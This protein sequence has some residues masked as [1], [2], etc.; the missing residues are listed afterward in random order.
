[1]STIKQKETFTRRYYLKHIAVVFASI[2]L[3]FK[4]PSYFTHTKTANSEQNTKTTGIK[5]KTVDQYK[6]GLNHER[7]L[8][9]FI[10]K[11]LKANKSSFYA[12]NGVCTHQRCALR[13][14]SSLSNIVCPC[15]G[16]RFS[17][18]GEVLRGPATKSL[19]H[20]ALSTKDNTLIVHK[21]TIVDSNWRL[22]IMNSF[23]Y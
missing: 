1:M 3:A 18:N 14:D 12:I 20:F 19:P 2:I 16:A 10:I 8:Q 17:F 11:E 21:D 4:L 23:E 7:L 15:H 5:L 13:G 6:E 22:D 9:V